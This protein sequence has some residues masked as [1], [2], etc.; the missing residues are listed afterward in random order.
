M[1]KFSG[2]KTIAGLRLDSISLQSLFLE[3]QKILR[4]FENHIRSKKARRGGRFQDGSNVY[5][6]FANTMESAF[7]LICC[8]LSEL[9][10]L[11]D[12]SSFCGNWRVP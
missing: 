1:S 12:H 11:P 6:L 4:L 8:S 3:L 9:Q 7:A 2:P 10:Q 5:D